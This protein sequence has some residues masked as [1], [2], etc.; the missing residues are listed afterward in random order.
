[1]VKW[2]VLL[3]LLSSELIAQQMPVIVGTIRN[4]AQGEI[5]F[6]TEPCNTDSTMHFA[7]IRDD[8]GKLSLSGCWKLI[9][10]DVVVKWSDGDVYSYPVSNVQFTQEYNEWY[11]ERQR[12]KGR[13]AP[14]L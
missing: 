8:G 7:F 1:M 6:T 5:T 9:G 12:Q 13:T 14:V 11:A 2:I 3:S 10:Y 4:R